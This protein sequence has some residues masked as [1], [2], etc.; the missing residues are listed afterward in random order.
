MYDYIG[1][2][3]N[4]AKTNLAKIRKVKLEKI[5][6][7]K[8]RGIEPY[9][10]ISGE[11]TPIAIAKKQFDDLVL[12]QQKIYLAGRV[13]AKR[14][15]GGST[16]ADIYDGTAKIQIYLKQDS[17][18]PDKYKQFLDYI[19]IGDFISSC[20]S[21]FITRKG[22]QTQE[23]YD[24]MILAKAVLPLPEKWHGLADIDERFRK[25]YLDLLMNEDVKNK[26]IKRSHIIRSLR[27]FLE[28]EGFMEV[29]TPILQTIPGGALAKPFKTRL[30]A[31]KMDLYLRVAP[32]LYLK[33]LL[34]GGY[35]KVYEIGRC[36]RNEGMDSTH[37]PDF[38]ML[39]CY[40]AYKNYQNF[41]DMTERL[42]KHV[43][44]EVIPNS[45][46][47][48]EREGQ[49]INL[50]QKFARAEMIGLIK[51]HTGI[52]YDLVSEKELLKEAR[53]LKIKIPKGSS[54]G[55]IAD[56]IY[57]EM[58]RPHLIQPTFV[59]NHPIEL[60]PLAKKITD[61]P[62]KAARFQL[63]IAGMEIANAYSELN[64]PEEQLS[65]F[66]AQEKIAKKGDEEAQRMDMDFVEALEYGMP[67][68][69]G[70][71]VG[72]ERLVALLTNSHSIR[73]TMLFPTMK[74]KK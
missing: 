58:V 44:A 63:V 71:G 20:G 14:E 19:D 1:F 62:Q 52:D 38:T 55:K 28:T 23:L 25:R 72:I 45:G 32:E 30:N 64:D 7:L 49:I 47:Q 39:E 57:K 54:K 33:R 60:S 65:R 3:M 36:F 22:E 31:L 26:F 15:H 16:F 42:I 69:A 8:K 73:E 51:K 29:E 37:N 40:E 5:N 2:L 11:I 67:P 17:L 9:P 21:F 10:E 43:T 24:F 50:Q 27:K 34:I 6:A 53:I 66:K 74:P 4:P 56:E 41:M 18:G 61:D 68:A 13:M 48:I 59:I 46:F 35:P 12:S 70:L